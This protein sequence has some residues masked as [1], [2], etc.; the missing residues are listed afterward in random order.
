MMQRWSLNRKILFP[1]LLALSA[2]FA[3]LLWIL[4]R[5]TH[6]NM[7]AAEVTNA[8]ATIAQFKTLRAYYTEQVVAKVLKGSSLEAVVDH[9]H[10]ADAVPLPASMIHDLSRILGQDSTGVFLRLYS[11][12]PFPN[13]ADRKL[14]PFMEE[15][16]EALRLDP[17]ATFV[18][19]EDIGGS[20]FVRVAIS[21]P[22]VKQ[23]CVD[24]HNS[25]PQ[26]PKRDWKLGD[27]R[28]VLEV[29]KPL[30]AQRAASRAMFWKIFALL[31]VGLGS[32]VILVVLLTRI[33][34]IK[35]LFGCAE[36]L[37]TA[38]DQINLASGQVSQSSQSLAIGASQ[39]ASA[40]EETSAS[41]QGI[42]SMT[43]QNSETARN[44]NALAAEAQGDVEDGRQAM[45]RMGEAVG[46]IRDSADQTSRIIKTIDE[47]AFQTN[48]LALN[49][50]VEAARA[51]D[52]G[53]GFA[54]VAEEVRNLAH[55]S[56]EAARSTSTLLEESR[57]NAAR[58]V[59]VSD[60][61]GGMLARIVEKVQRLAQLVRAISD[62]TEE[63]AKGIE[64]IGTAVNQ[65][66][67]VTQANAASAEESASAGE[68][69][70]ARA[71]ELGEMV[72]VLVGVVQGA[73]APDA[74]G[75]AGGPGG[76]SPGVRRDGPEE[77]LQ[78]PD[79]SARPAGRQRR[80]AMARAAH[81][82]AR[83]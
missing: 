21:D 30:G 11:D 62:A 19:E 39:Q 56:A 8:R 43:R 22:M 79:W 67:K 28:G 14:D 7:V 32:L 57:Q 74:D 34:V 44:A 83:G 25:H 71:R 23:A 41:L 20:P 80:S 82:S 6:G 55:R 70:L 46:R 1:L 58:G 60:E 59:E 2:C 24:C 50:A 75:R 26:S 4:S 42:S 10:R 63:Q 45:E 31:A 40:L 35:P 33:A 17:T 69:L 51:G 54:V 65:M 37:R 12:F 64:Q 9:H 27:V 77:R 16:M 48:L 72:T 52:A 38:G 53:K 81:P 3:I 76:G 73:G 66:E 5:A 15:A 61:V 13:R 47:I 68:E 36:T 18:R 29:D 49:A 78:G